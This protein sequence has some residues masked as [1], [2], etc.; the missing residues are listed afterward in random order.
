MNPG[1]FVALPF[2]GKKLVRDFGGEDGTKSFRI[3]N[4]PSVINGFGVPLSTTV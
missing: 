1:V 3:F 4:K 2:Y